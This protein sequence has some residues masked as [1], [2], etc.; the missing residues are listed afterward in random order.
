MTPLLR[1]SISRAHIAAF[2]CTQIRWVS[3]INAKEVSHF[4]RLAAT[5]WDPQGSSCLL[6]RMNPLRLSFINS[7]LPQSEL[8]DP[9]RWLNG[10]S[11][12]DVGCGG[13]ILAES[14]S[15]LGAAT[16]GLDA[17]PRAIRSCQGPYSNRSQAVYRKPA[18]LHMWFNS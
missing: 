12:L 18:K 3:T 10:Y 14:L 13:G 1:T 5:W 4:D 9:N 7:L 16:D 2:N 17:S 15:R 11:I 8:R 6:H